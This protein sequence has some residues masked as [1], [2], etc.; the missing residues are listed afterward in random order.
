[1][2]GSM[3]ASDRRGWRFVGQHGNQNAGDERPFMVQHWPPDPAARQM[4]ETARRALSERHRFWEDE[5]AV[6]LAEFGEEAAAR[7]RESLN[8]SFYG[9]EKPR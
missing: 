1:M 8:L 4:R 5:L 9:V 3:R 7:L 6:V 2:P